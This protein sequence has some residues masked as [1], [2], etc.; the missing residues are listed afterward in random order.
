[1]TK[2]AKDGTAENPTGG[3]NPAS[4][5]VGYG[6]P[7]VATRFPRGRSGNPL[8]RPKS[9]RG[10][11]TLRGAMRELLMSDVTVAVDGRRRT[12]L[13][14]EALVDALI[15]SAVAGNTGAARL[16]L[17]LAHRFVPPDETIADMHQALTHGPKA[18][19][20]QDSY[21]RYSDEERARMSYEWITRDMTD[22]SLGPDKPEEGQA[23]GNPSDG[24]PPAGSR[25]G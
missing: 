2:K 17:D 8:G 9:Q 3:G 25:G 21:N 4:F 10:K 19:T 12:M 13:R 15:A 5:K 6:K 11:V 14:I 20:P 16:A 7:P 22:E 23:D 1:M 24:D 18:L